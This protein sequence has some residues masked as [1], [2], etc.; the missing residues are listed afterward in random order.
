MREGRGRQGGEGTRRG[1][2]KPSNRRGGGGGGEGLL[3]QRGGS[4]EE[5]PRQKF[6]YS[7]EAAQRLNHSI[8]S[9]LILPHPSSSLLISLHFWPRYFTGSCL[10]IKAAE[11]TRRPQSS[12][13]TS[14][15]V[16]FRWQRVRKSVCWRRRKVC[17]GGG[18]EWAEWICGATK[19][20]AVRAAL[21]AGRSAPLS[22]RRG[23][24]KEVKQNT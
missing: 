24:R 4:A 8:I 22:D 2:Q 15:C 17:G 10:F 18:E 23:G 19:A 3:V 7:G 13:C 5:E 14:V 21:A 11:E 16:T 9:R 20:A 6:S 1:R 12:A